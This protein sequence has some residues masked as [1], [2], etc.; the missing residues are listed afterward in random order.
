MFCFVIN[1][2]CYILEQHCSFALLLIEEWDH[3]LII[4]GWD[5]TLNNERDGSL[6][7]N[8]SCAVQDAAPR[9]VLLWKLR[10]AL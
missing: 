7:I 8:C 4:F 5:S 10:S 3:E 2:V 9:E 1:A 6:E